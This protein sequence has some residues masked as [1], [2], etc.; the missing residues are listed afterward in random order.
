M[1]NSEET[2]LNIHGVSVLVSSS[3]EIA[4][5]VRHDHGRYV[6]DKI[7]Q[8]NLVFNLFVQK[9]DYNILPDLV[10]TTYHDDY[11]VYDDKDRRLIDFFGQALVVYETCRHEINIYCQSLE[12]LYDIFYLSFD[13][14]VGEELEEI[15]FSRIHCLGLEK[16]KKGI[17]LL[18]PPGAGKTTLALKFLKNE[19]INVLTEDIA[20]LKEGKLHGLHFRWGVRSDDV[21]E[22]QG[23]LMQREKHSDKL[24]IDASGLNLSQTASP[25]III[26]GQRTL[27]DKSVIKLVSRWKLLLSLFKSMVL[28]LE[29]QQ[30]LAYFLLRNYK[31][32]FSKVSIGWKRLRAMWSILSSSRT[33]EFTMGRD[34]DKNYSVLNDF[35][36]KSEDE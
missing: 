10:A 22:H 4:Q 11:I 5:W 25:G 16:D 17:L 33:Y 24:L 9:P 8:P 36:I 2:K 27:S 1:V 29:L 21:S 13:S 7:N 35:L 19:N 20:L 31:E 30:S 14:L 23:R 6:T 3:L 34:I 15:G 32:G 18:L 28:G 12:K 26:R